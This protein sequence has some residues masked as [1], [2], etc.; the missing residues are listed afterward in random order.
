MEGSTALWQGIWSEDSSPALWPSSWHVQL[1]VPLPHSSTLCPRGLEP[2][3]LNVW[4]RLRPTQTS[5]PQCCRLMGSVHSIWCPG[6][7][8]WRT[9]AGWREVIL[10]YHSCCTSWFTIIVSPGRRFWCC[11]FGDPGGRRR[12]RRSLDACFVLVGSTSSS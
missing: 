7:L 10:H 5:L 6:K 3:A 11:A 8:C 12:T 9:C 1:S 2:S 4:C